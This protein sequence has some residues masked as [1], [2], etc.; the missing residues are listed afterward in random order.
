MPLPYRE[1]FK[2]I[3][4]YVPGKPI[5]DVQKELGLTD[6][7]KLASNENPFGCSSKVIDVFKENAMSEVAIYPDGN[8]TVLREKLAKKHGLKPDQFIF[9]AGS[10]EIITFIAQ[11]FLNAD[12]ESIYATPSFTWYDTAV[13]ST[14]AKAVTIPLNDYTHD[15]EAM[16]NAITDK[17][18]VIWIC[19]PNNPTGTIVTS[20][21]MKDFLE[22]I[23]KD[24]VIVLDEAYYEYAQGDNYPET[25]PL[26]DKYPN[27][28]I[29]RTFSKAYGLASLRVGYG[30]ASSEV[31]SYLNRIRPPFNV[32]SLAQML[33]VTALDDQDF[34]DNTIKKTKE[35]LE[36]LYKAF[37][38]LN[39]PYVKSYTNFVWVETPLTAKEAFEKL[40]KKGIIIRPFFENWIRITV[41][42]KEQNIKLIDALKGIL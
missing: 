6:V 40:M 7:I 4:P 2:D 20:E 31:V 10:N 1:V 35:G 42:T 34:V 23:S 15:L 27:L 26:L 33:A 16:K 5:A 19:N 41:G 8:A 3:S 12:D 24:I 18:K 17:T 21:Q 38:E 36:L 14:G 25:I 9:G 13:K 32:N 29:L 39:I 22:N 11:L 30:V 37:D 28:I